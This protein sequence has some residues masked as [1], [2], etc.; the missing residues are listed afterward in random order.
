VVVCD[1][2]TKLTRSFLTMIWLELVFVSPVLAQMSALEESTLKAVFVERFTR[3]IDWPA[4]V[5]EDASSNHFVI[6]SLGRNEFSAT[7]SK[8]YANKTILGHPVLVISDAKLDTIE[9]CH[10][11][12]LSADVRGKVGEVLDRVEGMP[13]LTIGDTQGYAHQGVL[14]NFFNVNEKLRFE[15]NEKSMRNA[16]FDVSYKLLSYAV[17]VESD[18]E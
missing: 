9:R 5:L 14:I 3:F 13:I 1:G 18:A 2:M 7:L 4:T 8:V 12:Y 15:I 11:L 6:C 10:A 16:G 17:V